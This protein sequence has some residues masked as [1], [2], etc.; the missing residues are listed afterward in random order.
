M[1]NMKKRVLFGILIIFLMLSLSFIIGQEEETAE[2]KARACLE[3]KVEGKCASLS[4]EEKIFSLLA[5]GECKDE[6]LADSSYET[7]IKLTVQAILGLKE[8]G[9]DTSEAEEW[10]LSKNITTSD[11]YWYL[12][13]ENT[14]SISDYYSCT[15]TYG[16]SSNSI[17]I[18]LDKKISSISGE[19]T[20]LSKSTGDIAGYWLEID[21]TCYDK[22]FTIECDKDFLTTLLF[23]KGENSPIHVSEKISSASAGGTTTEKVSSSCFGNGGCDYE[24]SLW[25]ALV[26]DYL[27][28]DMSSY[29]PYL[30]VMADENFEYLPESFL[31]F[32]TDDFCSELLS[33]QYN[34]EYWQ[35]SGDKF[36]DTALALYSFQYKEL[37]EKTNAISWLEEVQGE[38][39]CWNSGN[40]R[41]TA[42]ILYSVWPKDFY[43]DGNGDEEEDCG[44]MGG[45]CM[46]AMTCQEIGGE[47]LDYYCFGAYV[48]CDR[49]QVLETCAEKEGEICESGETCSGTT[50]DASDL[51][52]G[53]TC[54]IGGDCEEPQPESECEQYDGIC[55][56][57]EC[58]EDEEE[59]SYTCDDYGDICCVEKAPKPERNYWWIWV[60]LLLIVLVVLGIV[61]KDK[62]KAFLR[63]IKSKFGKSK[64]GRGVI[65]KPKFPP[66]MPP[67]GGRVMPRRILPPTQRR[68]VRRPAA[69]RPKG[70]MSDVLKKLKEMGK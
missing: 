12:E 44:D 66:R 27:G 45:Y 59:A 51:D 5:I 4:S 8:S 14:E 6:V 1:C 38:D 55:R 47:K 18:G 32:L 53:E 20:C 7:D 43:I 11:I 41:D 28:Y 61:F 49:E 21:P 68:S 46:S 67:P 33:K 37:P 57:Y 31:C 69:A 15:I 22:E 60:L 26:L 16:G 17:I 23:R 48:C 54:C 56:S 42:F 58:E 30:I 29:L 50:V 62:L 70:E 13:I 24:A 39:G 2:D 3:E 9:V 35:V 34:D 40:I 25:A 63:K 65:Q 36:Y 19:G 10:L 52:Y 64:P